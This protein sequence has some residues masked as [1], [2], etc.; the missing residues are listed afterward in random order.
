MLSSIV[1]PEDFDISHIPPGAVS[2]L[3]EEIIEFSGFSSPRVAKKILDQK[4]EK[5]SSVRSLMKAFVLATIH[6]Y[7]PEFLDDLTYSQLAERVAL[8]EKIIEI[9][10][11]TAGMES[12]NVTLA[13][14]DP[15][16]ERQREAEKAARYNASRKE[17]EAA[18]EDPIARKLMGRG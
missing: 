17:G 3:C 15:E 10:Q 12:T 6:T 1:Y 4:R 9:Q 13:L 11:A 14:I 18:Y 5:A 8:A 7:T 16:E 2:S